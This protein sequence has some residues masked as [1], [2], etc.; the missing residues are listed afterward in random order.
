M[1]LTGPIASIIVA[2]IVV[3]GGLFAV[4]ALNP[5]P[6]TYATV[7]FEGGYTKLGVIKREKVYTNVAIRND[8]ST[9]FSGTFDEVIPQIER[10]VR[11]NGY[12]PS[13]ATWNKGTT[14]NAVA[15]V[16]WIASESDFKLET[17]RFERTASSEAP[18][19][20]AQVITDL[21]ALESKAKSE[22]EKNAA[23][24]LTFGP[25]P[26]QPLLLAKLAAALRE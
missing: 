15:G 4:G 16:E 14:V 11:E 1:K 21:K 3:L 10:S 17:D 13:N 25:F 6:H 8:E 22:R 18:L 5:P 24:A 19:T 12:T 7:N 20:V 23:E 2:I 9:V 26:Q